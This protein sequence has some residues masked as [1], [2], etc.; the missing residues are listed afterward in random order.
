MSEKGEERTA[1]C[2]LTKAE[3][4]CFYDR[5]VQNLSFVHLIKLSA[6]TPRHSQT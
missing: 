1:N 3:L 5:E 2:S 6:K 4:S